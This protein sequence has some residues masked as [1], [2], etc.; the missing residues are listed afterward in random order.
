ML[1]EKLHA[2]Q[3]VLGSASPRRQQLISQLGLHFRVQT[4]N[5]NEDAPIHLNGHETALYVAKE[6]A[7]ALLDNMS[8]ECILITA[9]T[10]VWQD[11]KR[12]GKP[13]NLNEAR[14]MLNLLNGTKHQVISGVCFTTLH[15][16]HCFNVATDVFFRKLTPAQISFY[17]NHGNPLDKAGAYGIQEWIG[18][19]GIE[20]IVGSYTNVVGLP[21][22]EF[23]DE[24]ERFVDTLNP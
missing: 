20:K 4:A 22:A 14:T 10:E 17:L 18:L 11:G 5:I 21:M 24:L 19:V 12:F 23:Y 9:D 2:Y 6:K 1:T 3:L 7:A 16:Q 8:N 15:K 13:E